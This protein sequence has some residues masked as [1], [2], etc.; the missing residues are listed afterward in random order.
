MTAFGTTTLAPSAEAQAPVSVMAPQT[1]VIQSFP[2]TDPTKMSVQEKADAAEI[3]PQI[4]AETR[5]VD[6]ETLLENRDVD[7]ETPKTG[8]RPSHDEPETRTVVQ[9][10]PGNRQV[11]G[12]TEAGFT[13]RGQMARA[14]GDLA[15]LL[16]LLLVP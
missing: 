9:A 12:D 10:D 2:S 14:V 15:Q 3:I 8:L 4:A 6:V 7:M 5:P 11:T 16:L 1:T 13:E